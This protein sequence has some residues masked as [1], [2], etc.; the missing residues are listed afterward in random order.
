MHQRSVENF[1]GSI[2]ENA[3]FRSPA[4]VSLIFDSIARLERINFQFEIP[5]SRLSF[6]LNKNIP[7]CVESCGSRIDIKA[8]PD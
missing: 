5:R 6:S 2:N 1:K 8:A 3:I 7:S 4:S